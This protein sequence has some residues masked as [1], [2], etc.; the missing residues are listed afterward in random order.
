MEQAPMNSVPPINPT[1]DNN[2]EQK[3][4]KGLKVAV[5]LLA[6]L[7]VAGIGFGGYEFYINN[8]KKNN[9]SQNATYETAVKAPE[10]SSTG[11][12]EI[13]EQKEID[14]TNEYVLR[15]LRQKLSKLHGLTY[16]SLEDYD[17]L[18]TAMAYN[19]I[20]HVYTN[21]L[22]SEQKTSISVKG[23]LRPVNSFVSLYYENYAQQISSYIQSR[24]DA[25]WWGNNIYSSDLDY[26][27]YGLA[28]K[29]YQDLFGGN[30]SISKQDI[31]TGVCGTEYLYVPSA[32]GFIEAPSGCGG[33][34][35]P[36]VYV[37]IDSYKARG[38]EA[39]FDVRTATAFA[40]DFSTSSDYTLY[41]GL[42]YNTKESN[43]NLPE[44]NYYENGKEIGSLSGNTESAETVFEQY[45]DQIK[46][47]RF[48]FKMN[49]DG[50][51]YFSNVEAL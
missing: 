34:G 10:Q 8:Q 13:A 9:V 25:S 49:K 5:V 4:G 2:P 11:K 45:G 44:S 18:R 28:N 37:K 33:A 39:Y 35:F 48:V 40:V 16:S 30:E 31:K 46:S 47:Y 20:D 6:I 14:I 12:S 23:E 17:T 42:Y 22:S 32:D 29:Y 7:A 50:V 24:D 38:D 41:D 43:V 19:F 51:F 27:P 26:I 3:N 36:L 1:I 21:T 15:D